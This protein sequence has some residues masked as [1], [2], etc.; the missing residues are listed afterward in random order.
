MGRG[1]V[2]GGW[3]GDEEAAGENQDYP[4]MTVLYEYEAAEEGEM[5]LW[6]GEIIYIV[7]E[8]EGWAQGFKDDGSEGMFPTNYCE[9]N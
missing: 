8:Y 2:G 1:R 3:G 7:E 9:K 5:S 4:S 6:E